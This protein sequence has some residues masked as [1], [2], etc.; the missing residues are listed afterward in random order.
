MA[1]GAACENYKGAFRLVFASFVRCPSKVWADF[2]YREETYE[3]KEE[4]KYEEKYGKRE[5]Q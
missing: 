2:A 5:I 4:E 3:C 1:V